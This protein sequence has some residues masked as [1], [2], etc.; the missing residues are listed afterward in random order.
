MASI[1]EMKKFLRDD[2]R[3]T[4]EF[5][6]KITETAGFR[7]V[8]CHGLEHSVDLDKIDDLHIY[9]LYSH[10]LREWQRRQ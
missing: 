6:K 9:Q 1:N 10:Y 5:F 7:S 3:P 4:P 8:K 2:V